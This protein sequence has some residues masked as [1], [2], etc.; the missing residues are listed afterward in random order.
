MRIQYGGSVSPDSVEDLMAMPDIDG[1]LVGGASLVAD[2]FTKIVA[3]SAPAGSVPAPAALSTN[4]LPSVESS[5]KLAST[6][7]TPSAPL[8][9]SVFTHA[10]ISHF[11]LDQLKSNGPRKGADVGS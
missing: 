8:Q 10:P 6:P 2:S 3:R 1:A 9:G 11:T 5:A 4:Y 7:A